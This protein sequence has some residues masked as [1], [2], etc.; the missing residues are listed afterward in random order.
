MLL[1]LDISTSC[2]GIAIFDDKH[3]LQELSHIKLKSKEGLFKKLD[4][5]IEHFQKYKE[6]HFTGIAIEEPLK[7]F[8][9]RFSS[10]DTIQKLTQMN[11]LVSGYLYL[12]LGIQPSYYNVNS[13]RKEAFPDLVI[14][15][16]HPSK[17]T[18]VWEC[19]MKMEP[20]IN[21]VYSQRTGK[22]IDENFD[23]CD[24]YV[25]G[26]AHILGLITSKKSVLSEAQKQS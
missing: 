8:K 4:E 22:L 16:G 11:S 19:V 13:A 17:K 14:P 10:A 21:W 6:I 24:A 20:T 1:A 2:I 3:K 18:L 25:V 15:Q 5:F 7:K 9:G 23:M 26:L 12:H